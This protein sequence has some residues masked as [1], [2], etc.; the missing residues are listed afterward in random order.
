[1]VL[2]GRLISNRD[3]S[4]FRVTELI[5][6]QFADTSVMSLGREVRLGTVIKL[7]SG[8]M[9][10]N[11]GEHKLLIAEGP[12][13][14]VVE[15]D[16][17]VFVEHGKIL[18]RNNAGSQFVVRTPLAKVIDLG[19]EFGVNVLSDKSA[20][21]SVYDGSVALSLLDGGQRGPMRLVEGHRAIIGREGAVETT[22]FDP[23]ADRSF[24]L[25][26][27][28]I[29]RRQASVAGPPPS[30]ARR[31]FK[32]DAVDGLIAV[33]SFV[34]GAGTQGSSWGFTRPVLRR[35]SLDSGGGTAA[36]LNVASGGGLMVSPR[37]SVEFRV[38]P[39]REANF[40]GGSGAQG[41]FDAP[42]R[43]IWLAWRSAHNSAQA[44][45]AGLTLFK[46]EGQVTQEQL[47]VGVRPGTS[48]YVVSAPAAEGAEAIDHPLAYPLYKDNGGDLTSDGRVHLWIA[49]L[50]F[51]VDG[52]PDSISL[53]CD[54]AWNNIEDT[55]PIA[56]L[57]ASDLSFS[58]IA[59]QVDDE[60]ASVRFDFLV[61]TER[62]ESILETLRAL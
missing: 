30:H 40:N 53:W 21:V 54:G 24:V 16:S 10:M 7:T 56:E 43:E 29:W 15:S 27:E 62:F 37:Q 38:E 46:E 12:V 14:F 55:V 35:R 61:L 3:H 22:Q 23:A 18:A 5:D 48:T 45:A 42:G 59:L 49:R 57:A 19:T 36:S 51:G 17:S 11:C 25:P 47:F 39:S 58:G 60:S 8:V 28:V 32:G 4:S 6:V 31:R 9:Q 33:H 52:E 13:E 20:K 1:M 44:P 50:R 34:P 26:D 2:G 41:K